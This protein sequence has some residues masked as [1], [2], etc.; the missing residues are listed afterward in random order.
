MQGCVGTSRQHS[1][2]TLSGVITRALSIS[3]NISFLH[4]CQAVLFEFA[5]NLFAMSQN[6]PLNG[7]V[8]PRRPFEGQG[9]VSTMSTQ[10]GFPYGAPV[11]LIDDVDGWSHET[12]LNLSAAQFGGV[13]DPQPA[14]ILTDIVSTFDP[15][16]NPMRDDSSAQFDWMI[17]N[18]SPIPNNGLQ[19]QDNTNQLR[20]FEHND[21]AIGSSATSIES[22]FMPQNNVPILTVQP[23]VEQN[24]TNIVLSGDFDQSQLFSP[25]ASPIPNGEDFRLEDWINITPLST[26]MGTPGGNRSAHLP[27]TPEETSPWYM[28]SPSG[29]LG[30]Y[31]STGGSEGNTPSSIVI[32]ERPESLH[33]ASE[34][35]SPASF[36]QRIVPKP[37]SARTVH[38]PIVP[39]NNNPGTQATSVLDVS[40]H[41]APHAKSGPSHL[42]TSQ[43]WDS[44]VSAAKRK[45][46]E[47]AEE[48]R[49]DAKRVRKIG[50][51]VRCHMYKLKV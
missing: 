36:D 14:A 49:E 12:Y 51:C 8:L 23:Q 42:L 10:Q 4:L 41:S 37:K 21:A 9:A 29:S 40:T 26:P 15:P 11:Q 46:E 50:A 5:S 24:L 25:R 6:H 28:V 18:S 35:S 17:D 44:K 27:A 2:T 34:T 47:K 43:E 31:L 38:R 7:F 45:K 22:I 19:H 13:Q 32:V 16:G 3:L 30:A 20:T 33:E 1:L 39:T 48:S